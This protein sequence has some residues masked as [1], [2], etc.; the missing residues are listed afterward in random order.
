MS[1]KQNSQV[2]E[3]LSIL[4]EDVVKRIKTEEDPE[5]LTNYRKIFRKVVPLNLRSY[6][7]VYLAAK[8]ISKGNPTR[9][10]YKNSSSNQK[11][12]N[13]RRNFDGESFE[14]RQRVSPPEIPE[15]L[16]VTIFIGIGKNRRVFKK[17]LAGLI[18]N[19]CNL[20]RDRIGT[21][22]ILD[23]YSFVSLYKDDA[24][25]VIKILDGY[26]YR[27][28]KLNVS[29]SRKREDS[30][31]NDSGDSEDVELNSHDMQFFSENKDSAV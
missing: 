20:G 21:I 3:Q 14:S 9:F 17:D 12:K 15:D 27:G 23:N 2:T 31:V 26:D 6:A 28:R 5:V 4:F 13:E 25:S 18:A 16:A 19:V 22:K 11:E 8:M 30:F 24:D 7:A 10:Q 29:H 1:N